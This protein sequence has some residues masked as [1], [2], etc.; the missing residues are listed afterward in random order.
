MHYMT[1]VSL[2][3]SDEPFFNREF[4]PFDLQEELPSVTENPFTEDNANTLLE[5]A[6]AV[7]DWDILQ[8]VT[9]GYIEAKEIRYEGSLYKRKDV[10][11]QKHRVYLEDLHGKVS[12]IDKWIYAYL[13][14]HS[15]EP[16][17]IKMAYMAIFYV[18]S[19]KE[20]FGKTFEIRNRLV[21]EINRPVHRNEDD[22]IEISLQVES[23]E[24]EI[25][26]L[27]EMLNYQLL[28]IIVKTEVID[29]I[30]NYA[31]NAHNPSGR[32]DIEL[33][34]EMINIFDAVIEMHQ[35]L[36]SWAYSTIIDDVVERGCRKQCF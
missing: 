30:Q 32:V 31:K 25:R 14:Q 34:K 33:V 28:S 26:K 29:G 24:R 21:D 15:G 19:C 35:D 13:L 8:G 27:L 23:A 5:Y 18:H 11:L 12:S 2:E 6:T 10:P 20:I 22:I 36:R 4:I 7:N 17:K 1:A 3:M 16:Q 9:T